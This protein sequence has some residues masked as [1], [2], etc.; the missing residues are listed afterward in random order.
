[1]EYEKRFIDTARKMIQDKYEKPGTSPTEQPTPPS[2]VK[3][4]AADGQ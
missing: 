3:Y 4:Q 2:M 1:M